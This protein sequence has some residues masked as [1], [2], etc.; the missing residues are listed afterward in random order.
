MLLEFE[1][2]FALNPKKPLVTHMTKY[3]IDT[4]NTI[5]VRAKNIGVSPQVENEINTQVQQMLENGL[6]KPSKSPWAS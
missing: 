3:V 6:V 4:G 2:V 5:P 1:D